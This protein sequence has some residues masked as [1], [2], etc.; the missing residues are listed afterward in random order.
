MGTRAPSPLLR[1]AFVGGIHGGSGSTTISTGSVKRICA[2]KVSSS[3]RDFILE[4][5][6]TLALTALGASSASWVPTVATAQQQGGTIYE[7][8]AE[9][10]GRPF[11]FSQFKDQVTVI[12][13]VASE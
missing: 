9:L 11:P 6:A 12:V 1:R 5:S 3:R 8:T 13:N 7:Y 10:E 2:D 4:N